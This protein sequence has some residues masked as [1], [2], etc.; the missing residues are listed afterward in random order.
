MI[1][2]EKI[3]GTSM[4]RF[5]EVLRNI[6]LRDPSRVYGRVYVV[7]AYAGVT[8]QLLEHKKTGEPGVYARFANGGDFTSA[9]EALTGKLKAINAGLAPL[10]LDLARADGF[11]EK[12]MKELRALLDSMRHVLASGYVRRDSVLLAAREMLAAV[13]EAHSAF[14]SVEIL[15]AKGVEASLMDLSGFDDDDPLTIDERIHKCFTGVDVTRQVV[16]VTGYTKGVEGIMREFDRG[17]SEVTFSK[18][19]VELRADEAVIHKEYH[20]SSADPELV[21]AQNTVVVGMTNYDVADQLADVGMEAIHPKAAKPMELAGIAIRLK[22]TFEPEHPGTLITKDYVGSQARIEVIA[23]SPKVSAV[24]I[25]DPS[26]VGTVGFDL[27]VMEIFQ[28]HGI[29]YILKATN[30]NS[31]THVVWEKSVSSAF[32]EELENQ[33]QK[34]TVVPSAIVCV[35]GSNIAFPGV[36]ARATQA[37]AENGIN[38][39]AFSQSL[40]QTNMQFVIDRKDYKQAV[41][42]LN[43]ALCL[44]PP[45]QA[46]A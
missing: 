36:L 37:L 27:G 23:G 1:S 7:S 2:V 22:N 32:V 21:G 46:V 19:A 43:R 31:I 30:A 4:S 3:G 40:R 34:V 20:L 39:N 14:N 6:M 18:V 35:I 13:G 45:T 33:Y 9:I 5:D 16:V 29:S 38:V 24:E 44:N 15:R 11:I 25:H 12:R 28:R 17:Y 8:N 42:A 26:M 10:G 41:I